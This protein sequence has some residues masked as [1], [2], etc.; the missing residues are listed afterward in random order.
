MVKEARIGFG[1]EALAQSFIQATL[2]GQVELMIAASLQFST[3]GAG[4]VIIRGQEREILLFV[5][6]FRE[7]FEDIV[8]EERFRIAPM[9]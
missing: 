8:T 5:E 6:A 7:V 1:D 4:T 9:L 3:D 2:E